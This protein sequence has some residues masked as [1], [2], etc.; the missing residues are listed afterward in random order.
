MPQYTG[1]VTCFIQGAVAIVQQTACKLRLGIDKDRQNIHFGVPEVVALIPFA[2]QTF[3]AHTC[4]AI[5]TRCLHDV[6]QV[7][8]Q[9]LLQRH[10]AVHANI[11][12]LPEM[13]HLSSVG[14][15]FFAVTVRNKC[16]QFLAYKREHGAL[17]HI[18]G[19]GVD[20]Q[21]FQCNRV[22]L[23][24]SKIVFDPCIDIVCLMAGRS[25]CLR[26]QMH[27]AAGHRQLAVDRSALAGH[28]FVIGG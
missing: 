15:E 10:I 9:T 13:L 16:C 4:S 7:E 27:R 19:V 18:E 26:E 3:G 24:G 14:G 6:I 1:T 2:G 17:V 28:S 8:A 11:R 23:L 21:L 20:G 22:T 12:S 5:T 25:C